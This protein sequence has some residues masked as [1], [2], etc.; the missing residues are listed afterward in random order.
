M[1]ISKRKWAEMESRVDKCEEAVRL[2][3][4][5]DEETLGQMKKA[6]NEIKNSILGS[7]GEKR[8][9]YEVRS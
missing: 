4:K 3:V 8:G 2:L 6:L 7:S 1:W 9:C 5:N